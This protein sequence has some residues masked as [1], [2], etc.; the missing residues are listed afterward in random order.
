MG[1]AKGQV[2]TQMAGYKVLIG[3][4]WCVL[5]SAVCG[6]MFET[7]DRE[8]VQDMQCVGV[9]LRHRTGSVWEHV[10]DM[11]CVGVCLRHRTG[12]VWEHVQDRQCVGVC[13][14]HRTG[15]VWEYV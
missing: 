13:L 9:C 12:S 7:Q 10:Q 4:G 6:S 8:H 2:E 1:L 3:L 15:S 14:R 11:Q 5:R